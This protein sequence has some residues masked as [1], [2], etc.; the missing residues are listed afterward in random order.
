MAGH[1]EASVRPECD[2]LPAHKSAVQASAIMGKQVYDVRP[3]ARPKDRAGPFL[4][5]DDPI[6]VMLDLMRP[7]GPAD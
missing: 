4:A 2:R 3:V 5:G 1:V 6:A 7:T